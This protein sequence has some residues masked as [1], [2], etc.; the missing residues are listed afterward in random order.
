MLRWPTTGL[1]SW[2]KPL[3]LSAKKALAGKLG[4][5]KALEESGWG[6]VQALLDDRIVARSEELKERALRRRAGRVVARLA[7]QASKTAEGLHAEAEAR[8]ARAHAI[9]QA[10]AG[11]ERRM[12]VVSEQLSRSLRPAADAWK[13]DLALVFVGRD[14]DAAA[15]DPVLARYRVERALALIAPSLALALSALAPEASLSAA[16]LSPVARALVRAASGASFPDP[17]TLLPPLARAAVAT[18]VEQLFVLSVA[19]APETATQGVLRELR[20]FAQALGARD[21]TSDAS[22][23]A[24]LPLH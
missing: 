18:L 19:P 10:A 8:A 1:D 24:D 13:R 20:A 6:A 2:T 5:A 12:E 16:S 15:G 23:S 7:S 4:D 21:G 14:P 22:R 11:L 3:A 17:E 9:G